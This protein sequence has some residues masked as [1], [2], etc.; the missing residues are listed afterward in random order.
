MTSPA[1]S[2]FMSPSNKRNN[3]MPNG[4]GGQP[5]SAAEQFYSLAF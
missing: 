2:A 5:M 3:D 1:T 4:P